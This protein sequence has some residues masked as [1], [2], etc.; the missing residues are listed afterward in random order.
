MPSV[1]IDAG[2]LAAPPEHGSAEDAHRYVET[3]LDWSRLLDEPWVAIYMS[4]RASEALFDDGLFPLRDQLKHMFTANGIVE[5]DVNTVAQVVDR[6]LQLTPSFETYFSIRDVLAEKLSTEP[7][8][9]QLCSGTRLQSDLARCIVLIA[10]LR[11]HCR[12]PILDHSLILRRAPGRLIRVRAL[13]TLLDHQRT[14]LGAMPAPP[15]YFEGDVLVCDDFRGL[16][17]C[18]DEAAILLK[19]TDDVG[20]ET[21]MRTAIYKSRLANGTAPDW[22]DVPDHRIGHAFLSLL[23][24]IHP[25]PQL[26]SRLLRAVVETLEQT[27]MAA[28]HALRTGPGGDDPQRVRESDQAKAWRRDIDRDHHLHYW[29][30]EDGTVEVAS[31]S[32]PH[33][34]FTI[35]E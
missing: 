27:N 5:Y 26:A 19:A 7:N 4:E 11:Q 17:E 31:V 2:V 13:I 9:L 20:I 8:I 32:F 28:T 34:D 16:V 25:T 3:L 18:L 23:Q 6:L 35:P 21:A 15:E 10:I 30:C 24:E 22:D 1:T 29:S 14:D 33:D 12:E